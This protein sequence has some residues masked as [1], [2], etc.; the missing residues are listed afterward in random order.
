MVRKMKHTFT[1]L[2]NVS[3]KR[4][5]YCLRQ[6]HHCKANKRKKKFFYC[7]RKL[8]IIPPYSS[9]EERS[10]Y[11]QYL[12]AISCITSD[13]IEMPNM[14]KTGFA[15]MGSKKIS[16]IVTVKIQCKRKILC[17]I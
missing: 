6:I 2:N 16:D 1:V 7:I 15:L 4:V 11:T 8:V 12:N 13:K 3:E 17:S 10:N 14:N 9:N 5:K